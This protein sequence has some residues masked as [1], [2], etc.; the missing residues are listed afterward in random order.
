[1]V[2]I[3]VCQRI[4]CNADCGGTEEGYSRIHDCLRTAIGVI[5]CCATHSCHCNQNG[6]YASKKVSGHARFDGVL[7]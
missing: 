6:G 4:G 5:G 1:M 7:A 3:V 2:V